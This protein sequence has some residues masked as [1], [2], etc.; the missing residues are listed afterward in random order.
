MQS[1][2]TTPI[3]IYFYTSLH[4]II[5]NFEEAILLTTYASAC[6]IGAFLSEGPVGKDL[7]IGYAFTTLCKPETKYSIIE[8]GLITHN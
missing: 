5:Y 3:L 7:P 4:H 1:L 8:R 6:A 2:T